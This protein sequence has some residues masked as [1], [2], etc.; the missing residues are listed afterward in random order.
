MGSTSE[1]PI[2]ETL[3]DRESLD[4]VPRPALVL[5][6]LGVDVTGVQ[7]ISVCERAGEDGL[8]LLHEDSFVLLQRLHSVCRAVRGHAGLAVAGQDCF[9]VLGV[10]DKYRSLDEVVDILRIER[11]RGF[12]LSLESIVTRS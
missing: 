8:D 12:R 9:V 5:Q 11:K 10:D 3:P 6:S 1:I 4:C 7:K 2:S